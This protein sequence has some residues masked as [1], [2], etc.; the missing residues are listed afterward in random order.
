MGVNNVISLSGGKDSTA[1]LLMM[2]ERGEP[3]HSAVFYDWG[4]EFPEM[5]PH[6]AKLER[7]TGVKIVRLYPPRSFEYYAAA[8]PQLKRSGPL[9]GTLHRVGRGWPH[10]KR[11]WC[12][13]DKCDAIDAYVA[14]VPDVVECIGFAADEARRV[15]SLNMQRKIDTVRFPLIEW[16]VTEK[17]ALEYCLAQGYDWCGLYDWTDRVSCYCCPL[18]GKKKAKL[19]RERYPHLWQNMLHIDR[20]MSG[21]YKY[22]DWCPAMSVEDLD[23]LFASQDCQGCLDI[24]EKVGK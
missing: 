18:G 13:R 4:M 23:R 17:D 9:K 5:Y 2:L 20:G 8:H 22:R 6:L 14:T 11:R 3:I 7:D 19:V 21:A 10:M 1:V 12:T 24:A 15:S 16:G